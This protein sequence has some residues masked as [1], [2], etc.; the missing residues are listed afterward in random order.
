MGTNA[1]FDTRTIRAAEAGMI[2]PIARWC[3]CL[4]G[5]VPFRDALSALAAAIK[6]EAAAVCRVSTGKGRAS[7]SVFYDTAATEG[8]GPP[9][10]RSYARSVL[11]SY[12]DKAK[13]GMIWYKSMSDEETDPALERF[14]GA[15]RLT[16]LAVLPLFSDSR[17][18]DFLE[19]H[20]AARPGAVQQALLNII[21]GTLV[22]TWANR[23]PGLFTEAS[24]KERRLRRNAAVTAHLLSME[25]PAQLSRA[26]YR[27]CVL[28]SKGQPAKR[29]QSNL[30]ISKS[31]LRTHLRNI[32][33]KTGA[34]NLTE[35]VYHLVS[36][37]T[38]SGQL[39][40]RGSAA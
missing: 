26:E 38:F 16:E 15:R 11:G 40:R 12:L 8:K 21:S 20:F 4:H 3:E 17:H 28:L 6:G 22:H 18:A 25:N 24:L 23:S 9:L 32:Y 5:C 31:T 14:H 39:P 27:V 7:G 34:C 1:L 13:P 10:D 35:L 33:A 29:V 19:L 36:V 2:A 37:D 30:G